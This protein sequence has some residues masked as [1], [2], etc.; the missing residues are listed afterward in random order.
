MCGGSEEKGFRNR[1]AEAY[2]RRRQITDE[3]QP[4]FH[5]TKCPEGWTKNRRHLD[6]MRVMIKE[7]LRDIAAAAGCPDPRC[8]KP[9]YRLKS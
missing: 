5:K 6:A 8:Y 7:A 3:T 9:G 4:D 1:Y 2:A